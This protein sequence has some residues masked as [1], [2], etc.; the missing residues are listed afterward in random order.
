MVNASGLGSYKPVDLFFLPPL[1]NFA[2]VGLTAG[3]GVT[4]AVGAGAAGAAG[5]CGAGVVGVAAWTATGVEDSMLM[6]I[7]FLSVLLFRRPA[8]V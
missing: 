6:M 4:P 2:A 3:F 7:S 1:R 5:A 8:I